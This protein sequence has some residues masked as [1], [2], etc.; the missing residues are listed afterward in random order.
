MP[1]LR[2]RFRRLASVLILLLTPIYY[3]APWQASD[4][5]AQVLGLPF[6]LLY[7]VL[8]PG[9]LLMH[10]LSPRRYDW[11]ERATTAALFGLALFLLCAFLWALTASRRA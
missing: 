3:W 1:P 10:W 11:L 4:V 2:P 5:V 6:L 7:A 9:A 8:L